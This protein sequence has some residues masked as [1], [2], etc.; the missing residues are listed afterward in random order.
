M[1]GMHVRVVQGLEPMALLYDHAW[2]EV[3][4]WTAGQGMHG[5]QG[6]GSAWREV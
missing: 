6:R 2:R 4:A 3:A 5:M 1:Q